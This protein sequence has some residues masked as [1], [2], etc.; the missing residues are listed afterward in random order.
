MSWSGRLVD[1][2]GAILGFPDSVEGLF[3]SG[4]SAGNLTALAAARQ[5]IDGL[6]VWNQGVA[7]VLR[8]RSSR[9]IRRTTRSTVPSASLG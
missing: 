1:W 8:W 3:T 9:P 2:F 7:D 6:D 4:G 5:A